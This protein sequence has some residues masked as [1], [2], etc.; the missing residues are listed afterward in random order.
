MEI[1]FSVE[2]YGNMDDSTKEITDFVYNIKKN[3]K[4]NQD[5]GLS[6]KE[7]ELFIAYLAKTLKA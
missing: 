6:I 1:K 5:K 2:I 7:V 4:D 3:K